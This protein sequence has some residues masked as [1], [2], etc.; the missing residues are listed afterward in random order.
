[1]FLHFYFFLPESIF[2]FVSWKAQP[3]TLDYILL[4]SYLHQ[5]NRLL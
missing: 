3:Q 4:S 5:I 2:A 1:L